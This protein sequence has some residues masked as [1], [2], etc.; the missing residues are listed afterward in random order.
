MLHERYRPATWEDFAGHEKAVKIVRRVIDRPGYAGGAFW[1]DGPSGVGKTSL[2]W[3]ISRTLTAGDDYNIEEIDGDGCSVDRV[4]EL[5]ETLRYRSLTGGFRCVIVNEAHAMTARAVQAWLTLLERLP[6]QVVV[7]FTTTQGREESLFGDFDAPL[8]SRCLCVSLT[9][10]GIADAFA[11]R[12]MDIAKRE[13]LD[14]QPIA[15][16]K[17]LVA[18]CRNNLRAVL[19]EIEL[20]VMITD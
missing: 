18:D 20:G 16:Y 13:G 5:S 2:A 19:G 7:I 11:A 14:G 12:A 10:Y 17:R 4:R 8:K 6:S 9:T 15:K 1:I 3:L